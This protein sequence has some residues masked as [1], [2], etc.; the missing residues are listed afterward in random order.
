MSQILLY[1]RVYISIYLTNYPPIAHGPTGAAKRGKGHWQR[2]VR[3][4]L[5][6]LILLSRPLVRMS[7]YRLAGDGAFDIS[8]IATDVKSTK[9]NWKAIIYSLI[10]IVLALFLVWLVYE[11]VRRPDKDFIIGKFLLKV[12]PYMWGFVGTAIAFSCS[13]AGAA[14][15][16]YDPPPSPSTHPIRYHTLGES[17]S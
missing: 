16:V 9:V 15:Y 3:R 6:Q 10:A 8:T 1:L 11:T 4:K 5:T 17:L 7:G 12:S 14:W 13:V 2:A